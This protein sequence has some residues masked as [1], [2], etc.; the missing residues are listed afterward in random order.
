MEKR[1]GDEGN[2][3]ERVYLSKLLH[4]LQQD[5]VRNITLYDPGKVIKKNIEHASRQDPEVRERKGTKR[6]F[7]LWCLT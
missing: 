6:R 5:R 4:V 1:P 2:T 3:L 7:P